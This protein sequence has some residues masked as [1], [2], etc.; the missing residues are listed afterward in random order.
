MIIKKALLFCTLAVCFLFNLNAQ[1]L[2]PVKWESE[3]EKISDTE[4]KLVFKANID[5]GWYIY[6]ETPYWLLAG[7]MFLFGIIVT[8]SL[9]LYVER[10]SDIRHFVEEL[11]NEWIKALSFDADLCASGLIRT[12]FRYISPPGIRRKDGRQEH[13]AAGLVVVF[14]RRQCILLAAE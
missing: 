13:K 4:Y 11:N 9:I 5:K 7:W 14:H 12:R 8:V 10:D 6:S 1:I 2:E 3:V